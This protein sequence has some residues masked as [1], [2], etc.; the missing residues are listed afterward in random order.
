MQFMLM[1]F[2][3]NPYTTDLWIQKKSTFEMCVQKLLI[4]LFTHFCNTQNIFELY[5]FIWSH[6]QLILS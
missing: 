5:N 4:D 3:K 6:I 2:L 1:F